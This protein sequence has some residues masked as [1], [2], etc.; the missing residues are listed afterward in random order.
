MT[1]SIDE[2]QLIDFISSYSGDF[3]PSTVKGM[4]QYFHQSITTIHD[5]VVTHY[6]NPESFVDHLVGALKPLVE[7]GF[8][9]SILDEIKVHPLREHS[10][11]VSASFNRLTKEGELLQKVGASYIVI[12]TDSGF[13]IAAIMGQ[14]IDNIIK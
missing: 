12:S 13:K 9:H 5:N 6:D 7:T 8:S 1:K 2:N 14:D 3:K 10:H 11:C 4:A